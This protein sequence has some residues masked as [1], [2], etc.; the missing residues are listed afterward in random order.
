MQLHPA[1][2]EEAVRHCVESLAAGY[3]GLDFGEDVGDLMSTNQSALPENQRDYWA[4]AHE[5]A[6]GDTV[7]I[8]AHHFPFALVTIDG[9]YNFIRSTAPELGVWFRHFR[10][11]RDVRYYADMVTNAQ[12]WERITMTD[13]ISPLRDPTSLSYR[14]IEE[15]LY[16]P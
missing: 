9:E 1:N 8:I 3:I 10:K 7:L 11:V 12:L 13:T 16:R 15:W 4:F 5:M 6:I 14:L 2:P